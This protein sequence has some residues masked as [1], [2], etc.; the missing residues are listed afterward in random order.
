MNNAK[1]TVIICGVLVLMVG[2]LIYLN[3]DKF[4]SKSASISGGSDTP[5]GGDAPTE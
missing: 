2:C 5:A 4:A 3:R 1:I